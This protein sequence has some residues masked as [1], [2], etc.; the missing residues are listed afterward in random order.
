MV[1][2]DGPVL[3]VVVVEL[4]PLISGEEVVNAVEY[5]DGLEDLSY[6]T[7]EVEEWGV[8]HADVGDDGVDLGGL[9]ALGIDG[10]GGE[11]DDQHNE[12]GGEAAHEH[13]DLTQQVIDP[14]H[15]VLWHPDP[16]VLEEQEFFPDKVL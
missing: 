15:I 3:E 10:I 13:I 14:V 12:V 6:D 4:H 7:R 1:D 8:D 5:V 16:D 2:L 11:E 9:P